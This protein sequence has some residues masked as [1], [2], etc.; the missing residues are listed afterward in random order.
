MKTTKSFILLILSLI[1]CPQYIKA[2]TINIGP[3]QKITANMKLVE[4]CRTLSHFRFHSNC[5][6]IK[7]FKEDS[8]VSV[9]LSSPLYPY[10]SFACHPSLKKTLENKKISFKEKKKAVLNFYAPVIKYIEEIYSQPISLLE[11]KCISKRKQ[12]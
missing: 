9:D 6:E 12:K 7:K 2:Q 11:K 1:I 3:N 8:L 5:N 10:W 4:V